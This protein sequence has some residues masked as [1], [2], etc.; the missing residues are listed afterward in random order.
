MKL[1][2]IIFYLGKCSIYCFNIESITKIN[3]IL[4]TD[5]GNTKHYKINNENKIT[6]AS[7]ENGFMAFT[8]N[9]NNLENLYNDVLLRYKKCLDDRMSK[10]LDEK[11]RLSKISFDSIIIK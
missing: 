2:K 11:N 4:K 8:T 5:V 3:Y 1:Y 7:I 10:I 9:I 6:I